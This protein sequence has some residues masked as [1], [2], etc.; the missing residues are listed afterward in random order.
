MVLGHPGR[1]VRN[2]G[3]ELFMAVRHPIFFFFEQ[4]WSTWSFVRKAAKYIKST[5]T[6]NG[7]SLLKDLTSRLGEINSNMCLFSSEL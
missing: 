5:L 4:M 3:A 6:L 2:L 1:M 7:E